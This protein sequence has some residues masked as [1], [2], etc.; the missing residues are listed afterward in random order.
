M[1]SPSSASLLLL[2]PPPPT[3][4]RFFGFFIF[5][6]A[7]FY[8]PSLYPGLGLCT[9]G[10]MLHGFCALDGRSKGLEFGITE[11]SLMEVHSQIVLHIR[12]G[13]GLALLI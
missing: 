4:L 9:L 3:F 2:P 6:E 8:I 10:S 11:V 12:L 13:A 7:V 5:V 1:R